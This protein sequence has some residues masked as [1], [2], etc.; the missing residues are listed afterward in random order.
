[1]FMSAPNFVSILSNMSIMTAEWTYVE[2]LWM[3]WQDKREVLWKVNSKSRLAFCHSWVSYKSSDVVLNISAGMAEVQISF[4]LSPAVLSPPQ[5]TPDAGKEGARERKNG[6]VWIEEWSCL[7]LITAS[8]F[9][10]VNTWAVWCALI[11]KTLNTEPAT[12]NSAINLHFY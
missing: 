12:S 3:C 5:H 10:A 8:G 7:V 4:F 11:E 2:L 1:M 6:G 9:R